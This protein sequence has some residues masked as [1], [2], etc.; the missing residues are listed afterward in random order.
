MDISITATPTAASVGNPLTIDISHTLQSIDGGSPIKMNMSAI[1]TG[2]LIGTTGGVMSMSVQ[3]FLDD[4]AGGT[5]LFSVPGTHS[6]ALIGPASLPYNPGAFG[7]SSGTTTFNANQPFSVDLR[8][9]LTVTTF[10]QGMGSSIDNSMDVTPT[11]EP[12]SLLVALSGAPLMAG[13]VWLRRRKSA[14]KADV[15]ADAK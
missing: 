10:A 5:N 4:T 11:P 3:G 6:T 1:G 8:T 7:Q 15:E 2:H 14:R 9:V 13:L 12:A